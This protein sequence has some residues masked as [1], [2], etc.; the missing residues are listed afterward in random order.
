M[1][2]KYLNE[3]PYFFHYNTVTFY[4]YYIFENVSILKYIDRIVYYNYHTYRQ[5]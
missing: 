4:V 3:K 1:T 5:G 2:N